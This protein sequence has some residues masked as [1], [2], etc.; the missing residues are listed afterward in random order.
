MNFE[1]IK[2]L[3]SLY[4]HE[5]WDVKV[6]QEVEIHEKIKDGNNERIWRFKWLIIKTSKRNNHTWTF[7]VRGKVLGI[8]VE[9]VYPISSQTISKIVLLDEK[10]IRRAKLYYLRD[11]IGKDARLKSLFVWEKSYNRWKEITKRSLN[12][13]IQEDVKTVEEPKTETSANE[14]KETE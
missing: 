14:T 3:A 6:W 4:N 2:K 7:T 9:K 8:D 13:S 11:K 10:R 1:R 5:L 12:V